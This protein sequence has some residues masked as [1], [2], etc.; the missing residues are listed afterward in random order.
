MLNR[1]L[2]VVVCAVL[3]AMLPD[4]SAAQ[5]GAEGRMQALAG[6]HTLITQQLAKEAL[7]V[8]LGIDREQNLGRL[9]TARTRFDR[10]LRGLRAGDA[11]LGLSPASDPDLLAELDRVDA[12]WQE[13]DSELRTG[14]ANGRF[15]PDQVDR[16]AGLSMPLLDALDAAAAAGA[17]PRDG[18]YFSMLLVAIELSD[19]QRTL[20]EQMSKELLLI[21]YGRNVEESRARL[22]MTASQFGESLDGLIYGDI[23]RLL[24]P[25]PTDSIR[26]QLAVVSQVWRVE[27]RPIID[28]AIAGDPLDR[29]SITQFTETCDRLLEES[30]IVVSLY[31][32][33]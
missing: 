17:F 31:L 19:R 23:D 1:V 4:L 12:V 13:M 11:A 9:E 15:T 5:R 16:I 21:A 33:L 25:A 2:T 24:L 20:V 10:A 8:A 6:S 30:S 14:L 32:E 27:L 29:Q 18:Q 28:A 7:L 3:V 26:D 22:Q